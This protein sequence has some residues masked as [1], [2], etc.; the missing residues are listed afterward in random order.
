[1]TG[2]VCCARLFV[3]CI[4]GAGLVLQTLCRSST[5]DG[6]QPATACPATSCSVC[7]QWLLTEKHASVFLAPCSCEYGARTAVWGGV[8]GLWRGWCVVYWGRRLPPP[9]CYHNTSCTIVAVPRSIHSLLR[10][11]KGCYNRA[12]ESSLRH[13]GNQ[14][15]PRGTAVTMAWRPLSQAPFLRLLFRGWFSWWPFITLR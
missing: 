3:W 4:G 6:V 10:A 14:R 13:D 1:M 11:E 8:V 5:A 7:I 15:R 9:V 12:A 2:C